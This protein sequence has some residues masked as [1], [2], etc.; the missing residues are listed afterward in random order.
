MKKANDSDAG[1]L[2]VA[3]AAKALG[4]TAETVRRYIREG[5]LQAEKRKLIGLKKI[6]MVS[7]EE[8]RRLSEV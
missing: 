7:K 5:K 4:V 1:M 3:E 6:W 2:T 8:I